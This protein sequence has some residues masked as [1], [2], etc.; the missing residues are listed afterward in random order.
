MRQHEGSS[1]RQPTSRSSTTAAVC[2]A[3]CLVGAGSIARPAAAETI[4]VEYQALAKT[5]VGQPFGL[6]V[7]LDTPVSG[8]LQ[9]DTATPDS[10]AAAT[11]GT[12]VHL[13][14]GGFVA[15]FLGHRVAG[16]ATP[17]WTAAQSDTLRMYDGPRTVGP[18]GGV[19]SF[20]AVPSDAIEAFLA[21][22]PQDDTLLPND[23]L[24]DPW[25]AFD[26]GFLGDPHTFTIESSPDDRMLLQFSGTTQV[27]VD[28][29]GDGYTVSQGDCD[30]ADATVYPGASESC[31]GKDNDCNDL[32]DDG[33]D[34][35]SDMVADVCDNCPGVANADQADLDGDGL[36]DLCDPI[37]GTGGT[38]PVGTWE[39]GVKDQ[40]AG[41]AYVTVDQD[42]T[43]GGYGVMRD[44]DGFYL[45]DGDWRYADAKCQIGGRYHM[46]VEPLLPDAAHP[47]LVSTE[48]LTLSAKVKAGKRFSASLLD[49]AGEKSYK[50]TAKP[51]ADCS[52]HDW[53]IGDWAAE[54][55]RG[56]EL[57]SE[58][59]QVSAPP[60]AYPCVY[61][62]SGSGS[63]TGGNYTVCGRMI[64]DRKGRSDGVVDLDCDGALNRSFHGALTPPNPARAK[65]GKMKLKGV[66]AAGVKFTLRAVQ[67]TGP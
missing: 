46:T 35:D 49:G 59:F 11:R 16:S 36:G 67:Q 48:Q 50:L 61:D 62:L 12:Y 8:Y 54:V 7:P 28:Q 24:P 25:P 27:E 10:D 14:G 18:E 22:T 47:A 29:D 58:D 20:D 33:D 53:V 2:A 65:P 45:V 56:K 30:D 17:T 37:C 26:F 64:L 51:A 13:L 42:F 5:V 31:D 63:G 23:D 3:L 15:D 32:I 57:G 55:K 6:T 66:D 21:I 9:Y 60:A 43:L 34:T 4:R 41:L 1:L 19:M 40:G 38:L 44:L 52:L 39:V